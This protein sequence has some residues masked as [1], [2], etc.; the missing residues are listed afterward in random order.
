MFFSRSVYGSF[1]RIKTYY[2][3]SVKWSKLDPKFKGCKL[4]GPEV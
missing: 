2:S 4:N 1:N 3:G